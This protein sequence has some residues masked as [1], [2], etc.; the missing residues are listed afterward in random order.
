MAAQF[1]PLA[2]VES[3]P[4]FLKKPFSCAMTMGEQ[5][6]SAIMPKRNLVV[7]GAPLAKARPAQALGRPARRAVKVTF[8]T[9]FR[10]K[11]RRFNSGEGE[12]IFWFGFMFKFVWG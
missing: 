1:A 7:S 6:V 11:S 2:T 12:F 8:R 10:R 9:V 4:Y 5:S 3:I